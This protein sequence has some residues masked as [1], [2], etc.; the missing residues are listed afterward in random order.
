MT[1]KFS[2][3]AASFVVATALFGARMLTSPPVSEAAT[4]PGINVGQIAFNAPENLPSFDDTYQRIPGCS[5][6]SAVERRRAHPDRRSPKIS[7][8]ARRSNSI[9]LTKAARARFDTLAAESIDAVFQAV[10]TAATQDG[11]MAAAK[12]LIDRVIPSRRGAPVSFHIRPLK[13]PE[14]CALFYADLLD[15]VGSGRLTP[16]EAQTI[17][18]IVSKRAELFGTIELTSRDRNVEI[19]ARRRRTRPATVIADPPPVRDHLTALAFRPWREA[20]F[21]LQ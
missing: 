4:N 12:L 6:R 11:D 15:D 1:R 21:H 13:T 5:T 19:A 14:D 18:A 3:I 9:T 17:S 7:V 10:L 8:G 20:Q 2:L 16:D